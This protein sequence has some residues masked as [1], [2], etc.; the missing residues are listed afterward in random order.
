MT[1]TKSERAASDQM[2]PFVR[3]SRN[4]TNAAPPATSRANKILP[5]RESGVV[6][7]SETMKNEKRSSAPLSRRWSGIASGSPSARDRARTR[8]A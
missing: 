1:G 4:W 8:S 3:K 6:F 5:A 7:G 2:R